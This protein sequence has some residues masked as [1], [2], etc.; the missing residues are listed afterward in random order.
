MR[1]EKTRERSS[2]VEQLQSDA[3][4]EAAV[5]SVHGGLRA[6]DAREMKGRIVLKKLEQTAEVD[7]SGAGRRETKVAEAMEIEGASEQGVRG[8]EAA[9]RRGGA[10]LLVEVQNTWLISDL[11]ETEQSRLRAGGLLVLGV[12]HRALGQRS[13]LS[14]QD[15][16]RFAGRL[17]SK[18]QQ[19]MGR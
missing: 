2:A 3:V 18:Q 1:V 9:D 7:S 17:A 12:I 8:G 6:V 5:F 10:E 11:S 14:P 16:D 13:H 4:M 19:Q 15:A